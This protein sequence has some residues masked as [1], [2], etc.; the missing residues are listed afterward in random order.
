MEWTGGQ[1]GPGTLFSYYC[2]LLVITTTVTTLP[3]NP[4]AIFRESGCL[5]CSGPR[6]EMMLPG[7]T[8]LDRKRLTLHPRYGNSVVL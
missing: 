5:A 8:T 6:S 1:A 3:L 4:D 7:L 2:K